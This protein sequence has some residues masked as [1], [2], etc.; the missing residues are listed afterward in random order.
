MLNKTA[1]LTDKAPVPFQGAPYSQAI[2]CGDFLFVSGQLPLNPST[3][4]VVG[5]AIEEQTEQVLLN[6]QAI[7]EQAGSNLDKVVKTSAFLA[8][9]EDYAAMNDVYRRYVGTVPP[10]RTAVA[11]GAFPRGILLEIDAIA[12]L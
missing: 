11:V 10:A 1:V 4:Q 6:L 12:H 5:S 9:F 7:L 3:G 2:R 8:R